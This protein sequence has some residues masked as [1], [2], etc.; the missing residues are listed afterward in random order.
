MCV[1]MCKRSDETIGQ[2][3]GGGASRQRRPFFA[4]SAANVGN[5]TPDLIPIGGRDRRASRPSIDGRSST[6]ISF[7]RDTLRAERI[8]HQN[9]NAASTAARLRQQQEEARRRTNTTDRLRQPNRYPPCHVFF[10]VLH[11]FQSRRP[12][13]PIESIAPTCS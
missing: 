5:N 8:A 7:T 12:E 2:R 1:C 11:L 3:T 10:S 13:P 9:R 6:R 4:A